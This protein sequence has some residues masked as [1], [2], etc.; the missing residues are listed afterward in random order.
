MDMH[1]LGTVSYLVFSTAGIPIAVSKF[2][3]KYNALGD[4]STSKK[5]L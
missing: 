4:Y 1:I 3:A 2:V 5:T